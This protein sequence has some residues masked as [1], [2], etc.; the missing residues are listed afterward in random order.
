[1]FRTVEQ[2]IPAHLISGAP[3]P[4]PV[5]VCLLYSADDPFA[6]RMVFPPEVSLSGAEVTWTFARSLLDEGL[7]TA[8]GGGD[9]RIRPCDR[10]RTLVELRSAEGVALLR[11]ATG[12]L[13]HFLL[14]AYTTVPAELETCAL[15]LDAGLAAL[16][17]GARDGGQD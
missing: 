10:S 4:T 6:V 13:R 7:R 2:S 5:T 11:F 17:G 3:R 9:V 15:D 12:R 16:L 1:M 8:A 14:H